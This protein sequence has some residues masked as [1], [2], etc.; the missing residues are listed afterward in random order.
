MDWTSPTSFQLAA[1]HEALLFAY[2]THLD[3]ETLLMLRLNRSYA[4]L[5]PVNATYENGLLALLVRSRAEGWLDKLV[6]AARQQR[7]QS[8]KLRLLERSGELTE[9]ELPEQAGV[10]EDIVRN[11]GEFADL[12]TWVKKL[13]SLGMRTCRIENPVNT[14][15]GTGWLVGPD[16][17]L[18]NWHV[19]DQAILGGSW[20]AQ[21]FVL[22]F[23]YAVTAAGPQ[24]GIEQHLASAWLVDSSPP[25]ACELGTGDGQA[26]VETLDFALLRLAQPVGSQP[27]PTGEARGWATLDANR[28]LPAERDLVFVVQHPEGL[29]VK[30]AAGDVAAVG[31]GSFRFFHTADTKGGSSGSV[32][33]DAR[34]Q[35]VGLHHAG[36]AAYNRGLIGKPERNQAVPIGLIAARLK[37][38]GHLVE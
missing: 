5:A 36:D 35:P 26:D 38:G 31:A 37:A 15:Q 6:R 27:G 1:L 11:S 30:L 34:L 10:L 24:G 12:M 18:T 25:A 7:P 28:A 2:P 8:P 4:V 32:I 20:K 9:V 3:F 16:L 22:R 21:D 14:A 29:P 19:I 17:V 33:V 23:D 13:E